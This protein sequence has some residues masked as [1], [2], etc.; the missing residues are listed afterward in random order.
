MGKREI[1]IIEN[2]GFKLCYIGRS[3]IRYRVDIV[4]DSSSKDKVVRIVR[5]RIAL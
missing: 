2:L 4:I 5:K 3:K 1:N